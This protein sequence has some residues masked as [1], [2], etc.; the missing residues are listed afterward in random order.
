MLFCPLQSTSTLLAA[1]V[2]LRGSHMEQ[3]LDNI[4]ILQ[5]LAV[6]VFRDNRSV[7]VAVSF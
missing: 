2:I 6:H 5:Y 3:C 4:D 7:H 1:V